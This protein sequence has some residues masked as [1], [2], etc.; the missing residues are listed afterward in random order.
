MR[1]CHVAEVE[2]D[3]PLRQGAEQR[4]HVEEVEGARWRRRSKRRMAQPGEQLGLQTLAA[5]IIGCVPYHPRH[6][7]TDRLWAIFHSKRGA[8]PIVC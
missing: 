7:I 3:T 4:C 6:P 5:S 8:S 1:C 2:G